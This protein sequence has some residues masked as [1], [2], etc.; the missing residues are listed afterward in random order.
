MTLPKITQ[1]GC[2]RGRISTQARTVPGHSQKPE[3]Q[4]SGGQQKNVKDTQGCCLYP[5][6]Q[7]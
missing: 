4:G 6:S 1:P 5:Y 3:G 7:L 2:G